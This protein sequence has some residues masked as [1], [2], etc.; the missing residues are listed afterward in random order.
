MKS[1]AILLIALLV[2]NAVAGQ[3]PPPRPPNKNN[4]PGKNEETKKGE[5]SD[6]ASEAIA[7]TWKDAFTLSVKGTVKNIGPA[8]N[9]GGRKVTLY[10]TVGEKGKKVKMKSWTTPAIKAGATHSFTYDTQDKK[11]W[12]AEVEWSL[13]LETGDSIVFDDI[14]VT[15]VDPGPNPGEKK[16]PAPPAPTPAPKLP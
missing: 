3:R 13:E 4:T 9:A 11:Q 16:K 7:A 6:L 8:D 14:R 5:I 15:K 12:A 2:T 10:A 1:L